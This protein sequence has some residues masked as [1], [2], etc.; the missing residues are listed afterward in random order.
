M[1]L[2]TASAMIREATPAVTPST[3]MA[4]IKP[5]TACR[6]RALRYRIAM[7]SSNRTLPILKGAVSISRI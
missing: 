4:V 2:V 5:T 1:P 7:K 6:R 3:E